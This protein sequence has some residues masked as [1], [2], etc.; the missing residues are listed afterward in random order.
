MP[1][2]CASEKLTLRHYNMS[3]CHVINHLLS[4]KMTE[5][6]LYQADSWAMGTCMAWQLCP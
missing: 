1:L 3:C 2:P 5:D 6:V 4:I